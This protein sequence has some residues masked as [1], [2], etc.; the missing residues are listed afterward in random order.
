M[1]YQG[2]A[3]K[4]V[5][6]LKHH[7]RYDYAPGAAQWMAQVAQPLLEPDTI[8]A[9]VPLHWTRLVKRRYNQAAMLSF[10]L[11]QR[12]LRPAVLDLLIR[13][14][15]TEDMT[16]LSFEA[17]SE[18][19]RRAIA[20]NPKRLGRISGAPVLLVD[21]LFAS[22]ATLVACTDACLSAGA[23]EVNILTL[24]RLAKDT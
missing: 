4:L 11:G 22:G 24:A 17:R 13:T 15:R 2:L 19:L 10:S 18:R 12:L 3:K 5:L 9:P 20:P 1:R 6:G 14:E 21:D 7:D 8:I 23:R 16:G